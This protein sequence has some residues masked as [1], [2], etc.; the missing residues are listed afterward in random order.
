VSHLEA[1]LQVDPNNSEA[2]NNIAT[3]K[4]AMKK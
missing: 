1:A 2:R 3:L 4:S